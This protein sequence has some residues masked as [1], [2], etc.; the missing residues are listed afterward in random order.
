MVTGPCKCICCAG[1]EVIIQESIITKNI[2]TVVKLPQKQALAKVLCDRHEVMSHRN[3]WVKGQVLHY[4]LGAIGNLT[5]WQML[6]PNQ[7]TVTAFE[8]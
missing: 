6:I 3:V 5:I 2:C 7:N 4:K 1:I 8:H